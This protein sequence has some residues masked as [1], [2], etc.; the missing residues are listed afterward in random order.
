MDVVGAS[1][2]WEATVNPTSC[3]IILTPK[4]PSLVISSVTWGRGRGYLCCYGGYMA[5]W[6]GLPCDIAPS[7]T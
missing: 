5:V 6:C 2:D 4:L 1:G 7:V 3:G